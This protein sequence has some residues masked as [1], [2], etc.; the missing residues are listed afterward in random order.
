MMIV[1]HRGDNGFYYPE[2]SIEGCLSVIMAGAD[3]IET[4]V[5]K[6]KD[7]VLI[8]MHDDTLY[9]TTNW[10]DMR[11]TNGLPTSKNI[12][13]WTY[14]ELT[15]LCLVSRAGEPTGYAI[16]RLED[17]IQVCKGRAFITLDKMQN[18]DWD[19]DIMP[20]LE[21]CQAYET[22]LVPYTYPVEKAAAIDK[23][24]RELG[25]KAY[26][27]ADARSAAKEEQSRS[28]LLEN[29]LPLNLRGVEFDPAAPDGY[30]ARVSG[31]GAKW[32]AETLKADHDH[33]AAWQA[34]YEMGCGYLMGNKV[35]DQ[36]D[37]MMSSY[38]DYSAIDNEGI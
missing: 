9:R 4:D 27:F 22:V 2:N 16:P 5:Q 6:T 21:K 36:L 20:L 31:S 28:A 23:A 26:Y 30:F 12:C 3:I 24:L 11:G 10:F 19:Q 34:L 38:P 13:D 7:G 1:A 14:D 37:F 35:Y 32:Y 17:L 25:S 8:L 15:S 18:F 33:E 29:Q